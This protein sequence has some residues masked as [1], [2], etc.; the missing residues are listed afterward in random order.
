MQQCWSIYRIC[1]R[2]K[3]KKKQ[4]KMGRQKWF[5]ILVR[6]SQSMT[7]QSKNMRHL[8]QSRTNSSISTIKKVTLEEGCTT[9]LSSLM[10]ASYALITPLNG[11]QPAITRVVT[12][13]TNLKH[14]HAQLCVQM[15]LNSQKSSTCFVQMSSA[16]YLQEPWSHL[17]QAKR[18]FMRTL[19]AS[20]KKVTYVPIKCLSQRKLIWMIWC[21]CG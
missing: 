1:Q 10:S 3:V 18:N 2:L 6:H 20:S 17:G 9:L 7:W 12:A 19:R 4:T 8:C 14:A 21:T 13:A 5:G 11:A 16:A 15:N